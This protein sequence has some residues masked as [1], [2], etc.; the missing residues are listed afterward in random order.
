MDKISGV[1]KITNKITGDFYKSKAWYEAHREECLAKSKTYNSKLCL[2]EGETFT[3]AA[4]RKRLCKQG[5]PHPT[6]EAKKYLISNHCK[7]NTSSQ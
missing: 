1:Y 7:P 6:L 2:Y 4:L 3:L 5:I